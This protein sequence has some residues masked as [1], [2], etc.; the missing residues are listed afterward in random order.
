[1]DP[2]AAIVLS[3]DQAI[4]LEPDQCGLDSGPA[5]LEYAREVGLDEPLVRMELAISDRSTKLSVNL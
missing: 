2:R 3:L 1:M 4:L 5:R